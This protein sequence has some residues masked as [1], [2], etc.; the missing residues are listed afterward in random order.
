MFFC[1]VERPAL[2]FI[3]LL[4]TSTL[5]ASLIHL[6]IFMS[7]WILIMCALPLII[8][9]F[10]NVLTFHVTHD[11][12]IFLEMRVLIEF[13]KISLGKSQKKENKL[14]QVCSDLLTD[15]IFNYRHLKFDRS[16]CNCLLCYFQMPINNKWYKTT[17]L[18]LN[19]PKLVLLTY[20]WT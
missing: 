13:L 16:Y 3:I 15:F 17:L 8:Y 18:S 11:D 10:I 1:R 6:F 5:C 2:I 7:P 20:L 9:L 4:I 14:V 19:F 12:G